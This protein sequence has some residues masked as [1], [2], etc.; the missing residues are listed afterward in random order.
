MSE[1]LAL[2]ET[3]LLKP[4][5]ANELAILADRFV[6]SGML[7]KSYQ[8]AAQVITAWQY[9]GELGLKPMSALRQ[10]AVINGTPSIFGD[11]P[12]SL[13]ERSGELDWRREFIIDEEM[14]EINWTNKNLKARPWGAVCIL[15]RKGREP[16]E[17]FYTIEEAKQAN[18]F[19]NDVWNRYTK[20]MLK[21]RARSQAIK[22]EF[23]DV[24]GG[25]AIAEY[26]QDAL[27]AVEW[28]ESEP[29]RITESE[30]Y[31]ADK[32]AAQAGTRQR[33]LSEVFDRIKELEK[34]GI[35]ESQLLEYLNIK[36]REELSELSASALEAVLDASFSIQ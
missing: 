7:P 4:K 18:L 29:I 35:K 9:A 22:D 23:S 13:V 2:D 20:I 36:S 21:Y 10:I 26:D 19:K 1:S 16:I 17:R 30:T 5:N 24:L 11:L 25:V 31:L 14:N 32:D 3:G 33:L 15:K 6:K 28:I 8:T 12:I 27:P 34:Q